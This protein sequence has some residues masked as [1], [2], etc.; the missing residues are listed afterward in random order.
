MAWTSPAVFIAHAK[1]TAAQLNAV[2]DNLR[3]IGEPWTAYTPTWTTTGT[4][5]SLGNGSLTGAY[6]KAGRLV[7]FRAVLTAGSSTTFGTG[8]WSLSLPSL[9][10][11]T[12]G[13]QPVPALGRDDSATDDYGL[14]AVIASGASTCAL[15]VATS[16]P[17]PNVT[18]SAPFTWATGDSLTVCGTYEAAA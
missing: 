5:P 13:R 15:R 17:W 6:V 4:A 7:V 9:A 14:A 1:L 2:Q 10:A 16:A 12:V 18:A 11:A 3:A 8:N